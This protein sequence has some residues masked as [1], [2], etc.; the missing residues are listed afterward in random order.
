M[1]TYHLNILSSNKT[2]TTTDLSYTFIDLSNNTEYTVSV[3]AEQSDSGLESSASSSIATTLH[4]PPTTP[5]DLSFVQVTSSSIILTYGASIPDSSSGTITYHLTLLPPDITYTTTDTTYTFTDLSNNVNYTMSMYGEQ[6]DSGLISSTVSTTT[7]TL[8]IP[9]T[10]PTDLSFSQITS[11]SIRLT[12]GAS[13][14][15]SSSGTITYHLTLLPPNT[16][17]ITTDVSYTIADL[18]NNTEYTVSIIAEQSDS[19]LDSSSASITT[20]TLHNSPTT[21]TDLSF[22]Q[23]N[24]NSMTMTY[25]ASIPDSSSGTITYH[26]TLLP[27]DITYTTT[28][29]SYTFIDLSNNTSYTV[30]IFGE[31]SE[32]GLDSSTVSLTGTTLHIPPIA[33][34]DL[35]F[36]DITSNSIRMI[37]SASIPDSNSGNITYYLTL[38]PPN[39]TYTTLDLSYTFTDLSY[40]T[41]Y[42]VS[43]IGEQSDSGL[44]SSA[45]SL[46]T[47]TLHIPPTAPTDLS[48]SNVTTSSFTLTYGASI[49]DSSSGTITYHLLLF[50][51]NATYTTTDLSYTFTELTNNTS[52]TVVIYGEQSDSG[53]DSSEV[54]LTTITEL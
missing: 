36:I 2:Y 40:N 5:T 35:S 51:P 27:P 14:P 53:L 25:G 49:P 26:L 16:T 4:I 19:G 31:Q 22:I 8:H 48:C 52:Y 44:D 37:Y 39:I 32:S 28:D 15:D 10:T 46:T 47:N 33:P 34:T 11:S 50:P 12:Y 3:I 54:S 45:V 43:I 41:S 1:I 7:K 13:I 21:P 23:I 38:S 17:Y 6:S 29:L 24:S 20:T 42:T 30:S 18:S 9:P